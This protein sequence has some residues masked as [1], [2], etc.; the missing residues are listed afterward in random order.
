MKEYRKILELLND[1]A[2]VNGSPS[3]HD[4]FE[5]LPGD[6]VL[7]E[8]NDLFPI[9]TTDLHL[10]DMVQKDVIETSQIDGSF[11]NDQ[12][13]HDYTT[14]LLPIIPARLRKYIY[15]LMKLQ[16]VVHIASTNFAEPTNIHKKI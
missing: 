13:Y 3:M 8:Q 7:F 10:L 4:T 2:V 6:T 1:A 16:D 14:V 5:W 11:P 9:R 12:F 15:S